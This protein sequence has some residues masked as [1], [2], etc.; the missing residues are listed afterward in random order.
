MRT[1]LCRYNLDCIIAE[2]QDNLDVT[3]TGH[4][5]HRKSVSFIMAVN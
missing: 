2:K 1:R 4:D 5:F 3:Q